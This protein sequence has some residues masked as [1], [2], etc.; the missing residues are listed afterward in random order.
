L[1]VPVDVHAAVGLQLPD[2]GMNAPPELL[3][4]ELCKSV[5]DLID[6]WHRSQR[7]VH[8]IMR[9]A[10]HAL[11]LGAFHRALISITIGLQK[12]LFCVTI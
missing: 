9:R 7:E 10:S 5:L 11:I 2:R 12:D 8:V 4:G 1:V 6:P 3:F